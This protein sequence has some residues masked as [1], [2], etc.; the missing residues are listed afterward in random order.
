MTNKSYTQRPY[1][2]DID[3]DWEEERKRQEEI[4]WERYDEITWN[5]EQDMLEYDNKAFN[6]MIDDYEAWGNID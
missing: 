3:I 5:I 6:E 2:G 4:N 1:I